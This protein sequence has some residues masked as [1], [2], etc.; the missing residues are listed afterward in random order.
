[1]NDIERKDLFASIADLARDR[2]AWREELTPSTRLVEDLG[3]DSLKLMELAVAIE[4]HFR[5]RIDEAAETEIVT[6]GDLVDA[7]AS[8]PATASATLNAAFEKCRGI[9]SRGLALVDRN[10]HTTR[11]SW[12]E[13][14]ESASHVAGRLQSLGSPPGARIGVVYPTGLEFVEAF[15]GI[16]LTGAIPVPL[17]PPVRLGR[18]DEYHRRTSAM[19]RAVDAHLL[20]C[21][22][23]VR[24][25]LGQTIAHSNLP[26]GC[27]TLAELPRGSF[28]PRHADPE[29]LCLIQFSSGTTRDPKPVALTHR[30]VMAQVTSLN[31]FWPDSEDVVHSGVSWLP[32]YH[33]M[34]LIGCLFAAVERRG[35]LTL[36]PPELFVAD[37]GIWLRTLS[38]TRATISPA[39]NFAYG[40]CVEKIREED[41]AN[42][43]LSH[44]SVALNGA[45]TVVGTVIRS[46]CDR[47]ADHGF[48]RDAITPVYGLSEAALAVSFSDIAR[49]YTSNRFSRQAL[50]DHRIREDP[51]GLEIVS[52]GRPIPGCEISIRR[53]DGSPVASDE[54]GRIWVTG[55]SLM[56]GYFGNDDATASVM[57]EGWLDTGDL[58]FLHAGDLYLT[59]RAKDVLILR[60]RNHLPHDVEIAVDAVPG[61][62]TGCSAA[63]SYLPEGAL[64]ED[65]LVFVERE[66]KSKRSE[67]RNLAENCRREIL[68]RTG[69]DPAHIQILEP[70]TLPRTSSG[71]IR[72]REALRRFLSRELL[73]P[74]PVNT[75]RMIG[76]MARSRAALKR[77]PPLSASRRGARAGKA[78]ERTSPEGE[79]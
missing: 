45:E 59:G 23:R 68:S 77:V 64:T 28:S 79:P 11:R 26:A 58:G 38:A 63:V 7:V 73:P 17:Y 70:G 75:V 71:K 53:D 27:L 4:N 33:D 37:P 36:I 30:A 42:V 51:D 25:I 12:A 60:G 40:M 22:A 67:V 41:V 6:V 3:L 74:K 13:I 46:F 24:R 66:R 20:L 8:A 35:D 62:R 61:A 14:Y 43:D 50:A 19:L 69:L 52:V 29:E 76:E 49:P 56:S 5:I 10:E 2:L 15:F 9:E 21:A 39:P 65:L 16:L 72:R 78:R 47:F 1:M 18:L 34:G 32:L 48:N 55:P 31:G 54:I 44:W 57:Q